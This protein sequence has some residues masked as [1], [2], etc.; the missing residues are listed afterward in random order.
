MAE[1]KKIEDFGQKIGGARKDLWKSRGL[2]V[3]DLDYMNI[4]E[5]DK[6]VKKD[7]I[8]PKPDYVKMLN[9][10]GYSRD[11]LYFIKS[12][13]DSIP[14]KPELGYSNSEDV[15][16]E[17][18]EAYINFIGEFKERLLDIKESKDIDKL[19]INYFINQHHQQ[20]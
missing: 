8:W 11:A 18:Q 14:A 5:C 2:M 16:R 19:N 17:K 6:Y 4:A 15:I 12:V 9:E 10:E 7:N 13:R 1:G 3:E 20:L